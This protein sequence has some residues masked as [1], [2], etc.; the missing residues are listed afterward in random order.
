M[1]S[2]VTRVL[3]VGL[4]ALIAVVL[5]ILVARAAPAP[6]RLETSPSLTTL[7]KIAI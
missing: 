3:Q 7:A 5:S 6:Q 2:I 1:R 4:W